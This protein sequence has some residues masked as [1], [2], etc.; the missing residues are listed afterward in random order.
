MNTSLPK[1]QILL[2]DM[3]SNARAKR[4]Q[5]I[6]NLSFGKKNYITLLDVKKRFSEIWSERDLFTTIDELN[7][8]NASDFLMENAVFYFFMRMIQINDS[9]FFEFES[10]QLKKLIFETI[11]FIHSNELMDENHAKEHASSDKDASEENNPEINAFC[12]LIDA[13]IP[14]EEYFDYALGFYVASASE[15][16][17]KKNPYWYLHFKQLFDYVGQAQNPTKFSILVNEIIVKY[18][19][20]FCD[21][22]TIDKKFLHT[23]LN[24]IERRISNHGYTHKF[25]TARNIQDIY[26]MVC[27]DSLV[28]GG[29]KQYILEKLIAKV[30]YNDYSISYSLQSNRDNAELANYFFK[31]FAFEDKKLENDFIRCDRDDYYTTP[32]LLLKNVFKVFKEEL[33]QNPGIVV[34]LYL[35]SM[36]MESDSFFSFFSLDKENEKDYELASHYL[37]KIDTTLNQENVINRNLEMRGE[38]GKYWRRYHDIFSG[39]KNAIK[40]GKSEECLE[41]QK[42]KRNLEMELDSCFDLKVKRDLLQRFLWLTIVFKCGLYYDNDEYVYKINSDRDKML[43]P[44]CNG[45]MSNEYANIEYINTNFKAILKKIGV[46]NEIDLSVDK[47]NDCKNIVLL[48]YNLSRAEFNSREFIINEINSIREIQKDVLHVDLKDVPKGEKYQAKAEEIKE[49]NKSSKINL[50]KLKQIDCGFILNTYSQSFYPFSS[51]SF[52]SKVISLNGNKQGLFSL[53][54]EHRVDC[55][56]IWETDNEYSDGELNWRIVNERGLTTRYLYRDRNSYTHHSDHSSV[57]ALMNPKNWENLLRA[58]AFYYMMLR[59]KMWSERVCHRDGYNIQEDDTFFQNLFL[60]S[61]VEDVY[62]ILVLLVQENAGISISKPPVI[63]DE[64]RYEKSCGKDASTVDDLLSY[65]K[66]HGKKK[67]VFSYSEIPES[68]DPNHN[69]FEMRLER[70]LKIMFMVNDFEPVDQKH[71]VKFMDFYTQ[72]NMEISIYLIYM[73]FAMNYCDDVKV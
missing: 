14:K 45:M 48:V 42:E 23:E 25:L 6:L 22:Q 58:L 13:T 38:K 24:L 47:I 4:V 60:Q 73:A 41:L 27:I 9:D 61:E 68:I 10:D 62:N 5:Q 12:Q 43:V 30:F 8:E 15:Y 46:E 18:F 11:D 51:K 1:L 34:C 71:S 19:Y 35:L 2:N 28:R 67:N 29:D 65:I 32:D 44:F 39:Y 20:I 33:D 16:M 3:L 64:N 31:N 49:Y 53:G 66:E 50:K 59:G 36:E 63:F 54:F 70:L 55:K 26:N 52:H 40:K 7:E 17:K 72:Y 56:L 57:N 37:R 69:I 21:L